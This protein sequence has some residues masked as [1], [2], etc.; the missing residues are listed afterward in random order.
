VGFLRGKSCCGEKSCYAWEGFGSAFCFSTAK[1]GPKAIPK[2]A[3]FVW[4]PEFF[5]RIKS[6]N[7]V[8]GK[9]ITIWK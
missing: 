4:I 9:K 2:A 8:L 5:Y 3:L 7:V 6:T 1:A